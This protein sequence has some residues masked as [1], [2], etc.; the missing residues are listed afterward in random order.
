[1]CGLVLEIELKE[2]KPWGK[3]YK[4]MNPTLYSFRHYSGLLETNS[5]KE[6]TSDIMKE[7]SSQKWAKSYYVSDP[8]AKLVNRYG[9]CMLSKYKYQ[10]CCMKDLESQMGRKMMLG[11]EYA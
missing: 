5:Q 6:V 3:S 9:N 7:L 2:C 10:Q 11:I 1:M 4:P 8:E